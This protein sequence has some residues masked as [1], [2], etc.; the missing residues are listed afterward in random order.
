MGE[1][2]GIVDGERKLQNNGNGIGDGG[3]LAQ[4][5]VC[6]HIEQRR[7][8][9]DDKKNNDLEIAA[10]RKEQ[11]R[12]DDHRRQRHDADHLLRDFP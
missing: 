9:K 1:N 12:H 6:A 4:P 2:D 11:H 8:R 3:Y 5:E 7:D 10:R